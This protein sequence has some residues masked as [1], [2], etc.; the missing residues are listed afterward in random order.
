MTVGEIA[1]DRGEKDV[2]GAGEGDHDQRIEEV[3][4]ADLL[5]EQCG[6]GADGAI[7]HRPGEVPPEQPEEEHGK[8]G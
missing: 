8:A 7:L 2:G 6:G 3:R 4:Y 1:D 5:D